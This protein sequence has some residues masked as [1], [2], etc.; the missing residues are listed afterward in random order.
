VSE[1]RIGTAVSAAYGLGGIA[2]SIKDAAVVNFLALFF[3]QVAGL[4]AALYG[5]AAA[6]GQ[7]VDAVL[8]PIIGTWSDNHR[9]RRGRRHPF[10]LAAIVPYAAVFA[11]MFSPPA[12]LGKWALFAWA[13]GTFIAARILLSIFAIPHAALGAELST[14]YAE[15]T[16]IAGIRTMLAWLVGIALPGMAY[17]WVF[18]DAGGHDGRLVRSNYLVYGLISAGLIVL[19]CGAATLGTRSQI[20]YLPI[21]TE[22]RR[23]APLDP[24]RD[25]IA[26]LRNRNFR[27][28][29]GALIL[30][31]AI[32]GVS[33]ILG[34]F[35][36]IYFWN[37]STKETSWIVWSSLLPTV[38]A[39]AVLTPLSER[40]D[41]KHLFLGSMLL[42]VVNSLWFAGGRLLGLLPPNGSPLLIALALGSNFVTILALVLNSTVWVSMIADIADEHEV[43]TGERKDGVFFAALAFGLKIPTGLGLVG[44]SLA[45]AW[46]GITQGMDPKAVP[47]DALLR[48]GLAAGPF[49]SLALLFPFALMMRFDLSRAR[50]AELRRIL[51]AR[52]VEKTA[53]A[54][55]PGEL[56]QRATG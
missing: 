4:P 15:R 35:A 30:I 11:L 38:A 39:F 13:A 29:F 44:G 8:D 7:I 3:I 26:S 36:W 1:R 32:T 43:T 5:L 12:G 54:N 25:V 34:T 40:F 41:K 19:V 23:L 2:T 53:P 22:R 16:R 9:S 56:A 20:P 37:F 33:T 31:G 42:F 46:V 28:V 48:L 10:M 27:L 52:A 49:V 17:Q 50:H 55:A 6:S 51:D 24:V 45:M 21:P 14:D 18:Q 47:A